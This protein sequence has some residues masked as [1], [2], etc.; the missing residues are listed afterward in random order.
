MPV[1]FVPPVGA[2]FDGAGRGDVEFTNGLN[3]HTARTLDGG[4]AIEEQCFRS[5]DIS[6]VDRGRADL[7]PCRPARML[8][9]AVAT[10]AREPGAD[11]DRRFELEGSGLAFIR[12]R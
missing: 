10:K 2:R 8:L 4:V 6:L 11:H 7:P 5:S 12:T 3:C 9:R 1:T